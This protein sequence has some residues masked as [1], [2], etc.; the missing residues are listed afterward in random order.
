MYLACMSTNKRVTIY[1]DPEL[2]RALRMKAA[3]TDTSMS[4]LV[5]QALRQSLADDADD[6]ASFRSRSK[7]ADMDFE[8]FVSALRQRGKL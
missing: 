4:E 1:L 3:E 7:E 5:N 2:H 6:L 8:E